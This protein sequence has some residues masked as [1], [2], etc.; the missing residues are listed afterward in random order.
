MPLLSTALESDHDIFSLDP[1]MV[2]VK[3]AAL[4]PGRPA[5]GPRHDRTLDR[6]A[7]MNKHATRLGPEGV[8]GSS[9]NSSRASKQPPIRAVEGSSWRARQAQIGRYVLSARRQRR[10][11]VVLSVCPAQFCAQ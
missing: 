10:G 4:I 9:W 6:F 7:I 3:A 11:V 8:D 2:I 1:A 5:S